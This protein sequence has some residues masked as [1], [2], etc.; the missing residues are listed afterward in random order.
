MLGELTIHPPGCK[1]PTVLRAKN[2]ENWPNSS[3]SYCK[4]YQAYF[5]GPPCIRYI[6]DFRESSLGM[7]VKRLWVVEEPPI[8]LCP[9]IVESVFTVCRCHE[10]DSPPSVRRPPAEIVTSRSSPARQKILPRLRYGF[11]PVLYEIAPTAETVPYC[12]LKAMQ[13]M[14]MDGKVRGEQF[15]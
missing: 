14:Q 1:F 2:Y 7:G 3:Q 15:G 6:R 12:E 10:I 13:N 4:N 8:Y 11:F 9:C 5:F